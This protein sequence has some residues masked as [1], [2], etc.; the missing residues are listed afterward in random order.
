MDPTSV[1]EDVGVCIEFTQGA[2]AGTTVGVLEFFV[3]MATKR[4]WPFYGASLWLD[5]HEE[6]S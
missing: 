4:I 5:F 1:G 6:M 2:V 3:A